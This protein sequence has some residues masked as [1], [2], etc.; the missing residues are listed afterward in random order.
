[1]LFLTLL[2]LSTFTVSSQSCYCDVMY[3]KMGCYHDPGSYG[4]NHQR[5]LRN[6]LLNW[7]HKVDWTD[8]WNNHL[9]N[10][11]CKCAELAKQNGYRY[12]GLQYYGECWSGIH[13][14]D[15]FNSSTSNK[16][17]GHRPDYKNCDDNSLTECIG[18]AHQNYIYEVTLE[19]AKGCGIETPS[20][21]EKQTT[22]TERPATGTERPITA[23]ETPTAGT[24]APTTPTEKPTPF[25][26]CDS[27]P[28][29]NGG[30]CYSPEGSRDYICEC[31][32]DFTGRNCQIPKG[33]K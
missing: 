16:C 20:P 13:S 6:L 32:D 21:T 4:N 14:S 15:L 10:M 27:Y 26:P 24:A 23:T 12:F 9:R 8:G 31:P 29:R 1:M 30:E 17:W 19:G 7:R 2:A 22:A 18:Q 25:D 5:P 3:K 28:C 11:A 33:R